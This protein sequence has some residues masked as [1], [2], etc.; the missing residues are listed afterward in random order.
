LAEAVDYETFTKTL[1]KGRPSSEI[2]EQKNFCD[3]F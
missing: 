2:G 3:I 1:V